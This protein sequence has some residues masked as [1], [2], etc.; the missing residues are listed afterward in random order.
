M[1]MDDGELFEIAAAR[2]GRTMLVIGAAGALV[3]AAWRGW[4]YGAGFAAG[5][6][7]SWFNFRW[8]KGFVESLGPSSKPA[9]AQARAT[10]LFVLRYLLL[11]VGGYVIVKYSN[12][13]LPAMLAGL[14]VALAAVVIEIAIQVR[15]ERRN[16]DH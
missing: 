10:A 8:M 11:V 16:L 14:F 12:I 2:I 3:A 9:G 6:A 1:A 5:S 13:S 15:Y 4:S 7:A